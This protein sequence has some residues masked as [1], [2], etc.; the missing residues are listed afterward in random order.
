MVYKKIIVT[1]SESNSTLKKFVFKNL[2]DILPSRSDLSDALKSKI[3]LINGKICNDNQILNAGDEVTCKFRKADYIKKKLLNLGVKLVYQSP[4][5]C[6]SKNAAVSEEKSIKYLNQIIVLYKPAGVAIPD[7]QKYAYSFS[8]F[9]D[10]DN[11]NENVDLEKKD[12]DYDLDFSN[13]DYIDPK[14]DLGLQD[15]IKNSLITRAA[16]AAKGFVVVNQMEKAS[17]GLVLIA[18][19]DKFISFIDSMLKNGNLIFD[20]QCICHGDLD[21]LLK[22]SGDIIDSSDENS[23]EI[24]FVTRAPEKRADFNNWEMRAGLENDSYKNLRFN[25]IDVT[26]SLQSG[27]ISNVSISVRKCF[28][29]GLIIRKY[30]SEIGYPIVGN[31]KHVKKLKNSSDKG[32]FLTLHRIRFLESFSPKLFDLEFNCDIPPKFINTLEREENFYNKKLERS[33]IEFESSLKDR[34]VTNEDKLIDFNPSHNKPLA[35]ITNHKEFCGYMF[36]VTE[37]TLIP[38]ISTEILVKASNEVLA[39]LSQTHIKNSNLFKNKNLTASSMKVLDLGTGTGCVLQSIVMKNRNSFDIFGAGIDISTD[40][41]HV[42]KKNAKE[43]GL[44]TKTFY[45][46]DEFSSFGNNEELLD[47]GP[48]DLVVCNP[49]YIS[50][51]KKKKL[52]F[53]TREYE[54]DVALYANNNGYEFYEQIYNS[55]ENL[56]LEQ[57]SKKFLAENFALIFEVGKGMVDDVIS[58]FKG[59]QVIG[60]W[61]DDQKNIRCVGFSKNIK[62]LV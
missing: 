5:F 8:D 17:C 46:R 13:S 11:E 48:F 19:G 1:D 32:L 56:Y 43:F 4:F 33:R 50:L 34:D 9:I 61:T 21:K 24:S 26:P 57:S 60:K 36:Y 41:L 54:P 27:K 12:L 10:C 62:S 37:E 18:C 55:I 2:R 58:L 16:H 39:S 31:S 7:I 49:P 22:N 15:F 25:K 52:N 45:I 44:E 28:A 40:A 51:D 29:G 47:L 35:Y 53:S 20:Y 59:Y 23:K 6:D 42:A 30:L 14:S 38:R 3:I